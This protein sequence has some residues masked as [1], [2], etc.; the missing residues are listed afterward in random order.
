MIHVQT[1]Y[2]SV[3]IWPN[4]RHL[5]AR[6][7]F[8]NCTSKRFKLLIFTYH[9]MLFHS[10]GILS[11]SMEIIQDSILVICFLA[12]FNLRV[13]SLSIWLGPICIRMR[14]LGPKF[15]YK[16][17]TQILILSLFNPIPMNLSTLYLILRRHILI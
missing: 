10:N 2:A 14:C 4:L 9:K 12:P 8:L 17:Q 7:I 3:Q 16:F 5:N 11:S 15:F 6:H 13:I 1:G